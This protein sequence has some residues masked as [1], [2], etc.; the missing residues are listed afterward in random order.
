MGASGKWVKALIGLKKPEREDHVSAYV[1]FFFFFFFLVLSLFCSIS[2]TLD[3]SRI[4]WAVRA[5][6]GGYGGLL[7]GS[8]GLHG[9]VLKGATERLLRGLSLHQWLMLL[10]QQWPR[11]FVLLLRILGLFG[12]NGQLSGSKLLF[13]ASW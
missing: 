9:R 5:R 4:R 3:L 11:C 13:V 2:K 7:L 8:W 12:K 10:Q 6:N 1:F